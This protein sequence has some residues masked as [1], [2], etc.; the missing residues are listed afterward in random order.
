[1]EDYVVMLSEDGEKL[2]EKLVKE[3]KDEIINN[4]T[5]NRKY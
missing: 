4:Y 2:V 1:M 5:V 3:P